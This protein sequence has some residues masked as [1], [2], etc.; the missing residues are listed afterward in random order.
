[1][2]RMSGLSDILKQGESERVEFKE[3]F[4]EEAT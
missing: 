1:M 3:S 4:Q 2:N